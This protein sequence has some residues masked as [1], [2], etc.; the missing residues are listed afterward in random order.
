MGHGSN[1]NLDVTSEMSKSSATDRN[2]NGKRPGKTYLVV[3][4]E[5]EPRAR[6]KVISRRTLNIQ[7][8]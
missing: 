4:K 5:S 8:S 1:W 2:S 6:I 3:H 7:S